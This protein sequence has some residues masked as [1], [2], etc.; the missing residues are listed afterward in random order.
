MIHVDIRLPLREFDLRVTAE[1]PRK[2]AILGPS[3]AGKSSLLES[4]L[5]LRD[6]LE[7]QVSLDGE[8]WHRG[9]KRL[10]PVHRRGLGYLPQA[11]PAPSFLNVQRMQAWSGRTIATRPL[12]DWLSHL[13][14]PIG[15]KAR[16]AR[17]SGGQLRRVALAQVLARSTRGLLLDEPFAGLDAAN[18]DRVRQACEAWQADTGGD[19]IL[20]AHEWE[21]VA[22]LVD[23]VAL[24]DQGE[25]LACQPVQSAGVRLGIL[26]AITLGGQ[27]SGHFRWSAIT[28]LEADIAEADG[29]FVWRG[30]ADPRIANG[31]QFVSGSYTIQ[32]PEGAFAPNRPLTV[33]LPK[34]EWQANAIES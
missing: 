16:L 2:L 23:H 3:G 14:V 13:D 18:R 33:L 12:Q 22:P 20:V 19:L 29:Y 6:G 1:F 32:G 24:M 7:G 25:W 10:V 27:P 26:G 30:Q 28:I 4:V 15:G 11:I 21:D 9:Q 17:L 31:S 8:T 5:G 34:S